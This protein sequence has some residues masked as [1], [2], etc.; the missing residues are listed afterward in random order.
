MVSSTSDD[1]S[2][3]NFSPD[4]T[5]CFQTSCPN[6]FKLR[7][8]FWCIIFLAHNLIYSDVIKKNSVAYSLDTLSELRAV[9]I[10]TLTKVPSDVP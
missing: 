4:V 9:E 8:K 3:A 5:L 1:N 10:T 2:I 7:K 6:A